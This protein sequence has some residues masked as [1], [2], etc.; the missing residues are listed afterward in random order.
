MGGSLLIAIHSKFLRKYK[1]RIFVMVHPVMF[2]GTGIE[3]KGGDKSL[4]NDDSF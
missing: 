3:E 2:M 4:H 1:K